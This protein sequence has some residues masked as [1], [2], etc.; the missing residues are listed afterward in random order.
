MF[1][2]RVVLW[3]EF[4]VKT[5]PEGKVPIRAEVN[6]PAILFLYLSLAINYGPALSQSRYFTINHR[7]SSVAAPLAR[8]VFV[9]G[10]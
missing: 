1:T 9:N 7:P 2:R 4:F 8:Y 6:A 10:E 5:Y 3:M